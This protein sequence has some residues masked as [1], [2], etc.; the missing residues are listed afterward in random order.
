MVDSEIWTD[1]TIFQGK[2]TYDNL[3]ANASIQPLPSLLL[4]NYIQ[5]VSLPGLNELVQDVG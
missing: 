2:T 4:F 1:L 3:L 5:C